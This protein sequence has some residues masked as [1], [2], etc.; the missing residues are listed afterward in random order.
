MD[1]RV[2]TPVIVVMSMAGMAMVVMIV[3]VVPA[4]IYRSP[5]A[6]KSGAIVGVSLAPSRRNST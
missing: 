2:T 6:A 4:Q 5:E 1:M 3:M